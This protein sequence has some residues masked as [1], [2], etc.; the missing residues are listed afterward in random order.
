VSADDPRLSEETRRLLRQLALRRH[1]TPEHLLNELV[2]AEYDREFPDKRVRAA[3]DAA[4]SPEER[5]AGFYAAM[6][7]TPPQVTPEADEWARRAIDRL[8][9]AGSDTRHAA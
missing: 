8:R 2:R 7:A 1:T 6:G 4:L 3:V 9:Q 5:G